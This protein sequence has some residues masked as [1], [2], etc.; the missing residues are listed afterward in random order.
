MQKR[1]EFD[2]GEMMGRNG[3]LGRMAEPF[4]KRIIMN[5]WGYDEDDYA[6]A[7]RLGLLQALDPGAMRYWLV[8]EPVC[9]AHCSA[10]INEGRP[11]YFDPMGML[12]RHRC[13]PGVCIHALSQLSPLI[14]DYYDHMMRGEDPNGMVFD[15]VAC[16]DPG[17]EYGGLG[18][19]L[20]RLRR[21]KMPLAE[22]VRFMIAM[23]LYLV[24]KN[25][26]AV[27]ECRAVREAP[28][29]GGPEPDEFM[30]GLPIAA[31]ELEAFLASPKRVKRLRSIERYRDRRIVVTV[32][33]AEACIAGHK[34]GDEFLLGPLGR[35]L[36]GEG[37]DGICIMALTRIWWR[38]MLMMERMASDG[39]FSGKLFD[40]PMSC[41]GA[42]LPL[43]AC[44][45]IMMKV[46]VRKA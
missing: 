21:E 4:M 7:N 25:K 20:F 9:S 31:E 29:S 14:Y 15:H 30:R 42:G 23:A 16:T 34:E 39:D 32:V 24:K 8:A 46:S 37:E 12:V 11:L 22:Y 28:V 40:L 44:G 27:G 17:L 43:G 35:V 45:R 41:Y 13:P 3:L 6:K 1:A 2:K 38:V 10:C 5:R 36:L 19:N 33:S 18:N 26:K